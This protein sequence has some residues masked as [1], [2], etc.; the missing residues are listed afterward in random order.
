MSMYGSGR[1]R[2][3]ATCPPVA[4][5]P[6]RVVTAPRRSAVDREQLLRELGNATATFGDGSGRWA[7]VETLATVLWV[8]YGRMA[9]AVRRLAD[10]GLTRR[11]PSGADYWQRIPTAPAR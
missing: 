6:R 8:D 2:R 5:E 4:A 10:E 1:D 11:H 7:S 3:A 9:G